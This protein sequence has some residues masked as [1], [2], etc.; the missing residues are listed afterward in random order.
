MIFW[1]CIHPRVVS[2]VSDYL[3]ET[4]HLLN[5]KISYFLQ[6]HRACVLSPLLSNIDGVNYNL[7]WNKRWKF[8]MTEFFFFDAINAGYFKDAIIFLSN[9]FNQVSMVDAFF[10]IWFKKIN[11][12][13]LPSSVKFSYRAHIYFLDIALKKNILIASSIIKMLTKHVIIVALLL[14]S[15]SFFNTL[16]SELIKYFPLFR[17]C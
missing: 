6:V 16:F 3:N 11:N 5:S 17:I 13:D 2:G 15:F 10:L 1:K 7:R 4:F 12:P 14:S 9:V 8:F